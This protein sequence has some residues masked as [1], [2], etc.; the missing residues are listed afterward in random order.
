MVRAAG[1]HPSLRRLRK[2]RVREY[3]GGW[4]LVTGTARDIGLGYAFARQLAAEGLNLILVDI[5][6]DELAARSAELRTEFGVDV[7]S[8]PCDMGDPDAIDRIAAATDGAEV[9][10]LV[11]NRWMCTAA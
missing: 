1:H 5:L 11:C 3:R 9:D 8:V 7:I 2:S 4:A 6:D 10:L